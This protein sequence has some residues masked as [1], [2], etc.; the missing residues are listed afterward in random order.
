MAGNGA[1]ARAPGARPS[2]V[3]ISQSPRWHRPSRRDGTGNSMAA[4]A[5]GMLGKNGSAPKPGASRHGRRRLMTDDRKQPAVSCVSCSLSPV[6]CPLCRGL[7]GKQAQQFPLE[8]G[9][10]D[11]PRPFPR[12]DQEVPPA[13][14]VHSIQPEH[15]AHSPPQAVA[16]DSIPHAHR[17]G[18]SQA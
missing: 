7:L 18:N 6:P 5:K 12:V 17:R 1:I 4:R 14:K 9:E 2:K 16:P 13:R 11:F 8:R 3:P 10:C 15:L